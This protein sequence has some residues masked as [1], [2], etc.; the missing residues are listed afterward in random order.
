MVAARGDGVTAHAM[1]I[2]GFEETGWRGLFRLAA[3]GAVCVAA[4]IPVQ[5]AIFVLSPPPTTVVAYYA[6]FQRSPVLALLDL[7]LVLT[8]DYLLMVPINLG[9]YVV[10]R[11]TERSFTTLALILSLMGLTL[12]LVSREP[13]FTLWSLSH[14][15]AAA[16]SEAQR[17]ALLGAG[18]A[19]YAMYRGSAFD[20]SYLFG[21]VSLLGF[22]VV[23][24]ASPWFRRAEAVVGIVTGATMLV[25]PT[26]P[27]IGVMLAFASL[28]P[29]TVWLVLL[30]RR[31]RVL[32]RPPCSKGV[33][34]GATAASPGAGEA[35]RGRRG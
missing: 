34:R 13:T 18:Q 26:V 15:Y 10:L 14:Q 4:A 6:L 17:T 23:M 5:V 24:L 9:L 3:V 25:P 30:A 20:F 16:T 28:V 35:P 2:G 11:R 7:D 29:T 12:Y 21:A 22:S 27:G 32:A 19:I 33:G 8:L 31:F 1:S